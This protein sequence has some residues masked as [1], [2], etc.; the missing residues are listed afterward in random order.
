MVALA[1]LLVAK[2]E[3]RA[4]DAAVPVEDLDAAESQSYGYGYGTKVQ[5][6]YSVATGRAE[7]VEALGPRVLTYQ[8]AS[9]LAP[10]F[11]CMD[12]APQ[13][14]PMTTLT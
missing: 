13:M 1:V 7:G 8:N 9:F 3:T 4:E 11:T 5:D 6:K 14:S 10:Q 12:L 2:T